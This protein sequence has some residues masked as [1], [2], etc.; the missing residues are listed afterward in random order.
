MGSWCGGWVSADFETFDFAV[1][2]DCGGGGCYGE[3]DDA[4]EERIGGVMVVEWGLD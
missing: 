3:V 2:D 4:G 1:R